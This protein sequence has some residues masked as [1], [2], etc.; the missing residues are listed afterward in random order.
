MD[1][2]A[3]IAFSRFGLGRRKDE[4]V[5]RD[6]RAWL[7]AQ[8]QEADTTPDYGMLT[9]AQALELVHQ[10]QMARAAGRGFTTESPN[11][12]TITQ[13]GAQPGASYPEQPPGMAMAGPMEPRHEKKTL[14]PE[15]LA[16]RQHEDAEVHAAIARMMTT[17]QGF[18]ERLVWFWFNHF[19]VANRNRATGATVG[20]YIRE[21]IRPNVTGSFRDM[22]FA[23]MRHPAM[24]TYLDQFHSIGPDSPMGERRHKGLNENL[25]RECLELHTI[26]PA[27]GYTQDDVTSFAK[28][29]TGWSVEIQKAPRGFVFEPRA[30]EPGEQNVLGQTW[31]DGEQ[32]GIAI[33][34]WL[35]THPATY[36][37]LAEKLVR[38]FVAD[39]PSPADVAHIEGVLSGTGGSLGAA[40]NA[41][42]DLP[43]AWTP[44]TKLRTPQ[45]Y[46]I[47]TMR[48]VGAH[49]EA[50]QQLPGTFAALG[51][52][53]FDA[54]FP[55]GWPDRAVDWSS[56]EAILQRVDFAYQFTHRVT[57]QEPADVAENTLGPLLGA[58]TLAQIRRAGSR[59][60][61]L[62][63][64]FSS[65]EFQRR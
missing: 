54:P 43:N 38:H 26:T 62:T 15:Q 36:H 40:A 30:H 2:T 10:E 41:L 5:P 14:T 21:A 7:R 46:V 11:Q 20:P 24:L 51:Q 23:V 29:L 49:P 31:P 22:L 50:E 42:V 18:R 48:A 34:E 61:G 13:R 27:A 56:P 52:K 32:G 16:A 63:V 35:S 3:A 47:A 33:L 28:I 19:T 8:L 39:D 57:D 53:L 37:H 64:L 44:L 58:E 9:S 4:P 45:E 55:I 65:P 6:A 12:I 25:A 59:Q 60:D 1:L 17:E